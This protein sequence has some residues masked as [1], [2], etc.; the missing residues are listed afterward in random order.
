M[1]PVPVQDVP[2]YKVVREAQS[3]FC[4]HDSWGY[5]NLCSLELVQEHFVELETGKLHFRYSIQ[6]SSYYLLYRLSEWHYHGLACATGSEMMSS[7]DVS[8]RLVQKRDRGNNHVNVDK[9][10][11]PTLVQQLEHRQQAR[12]RQKA[13]RSNGQD[14]LHHESLAQLN[15]DNNDAC[16]PNHQLSDKTSPTLRSRVSA[17][18]QAVNND[19]NVSSD[20]MECT[21][22]FRSAGRPYN[23][24]NTRYSHQLM[25][26]DRNISPAPHEQAE[27]HI[28]H[29]NHIAS[30]C[31]WMTSPEQENSSDDRKRLGRPSM[32]Q[33]ETRAGTS[34]NFTINDN[35]SG[36]TQE[37]QWNTVSVADSGVPFSRWTQQVMGEKSNDQNDMAQASSSPP[38]YTNQRQL[39]YNQDSSSLRGVCRNDPPVPP[40]MSVEAAPTRQH[41]SPSP[42]H[43]IELFH[44]PR[45]MSSSPDPGD[46][47]KTKSVGTLEPECITAD[48][49]IV[50]LSNNNDTSTPNQRGLDNSLHLSDLSMHERECGNDDMC[51]YSLSSTEEREPKSR[52]RSQKNGCDHCSH[53]RP[54]AKDEYGG[55]D[56]INVYGKE[57]GCSNFSP[58]FQKCNDDNDDVGHNNNSN[59]NN[60]NHFHHYHD[61]NVN[62][63]NGLE[64]TTQDVYQTHQHTLI[65][66]PLSPEQTLHTSAARAALAMQHLV[67]GDENPSE[68]GRP[69]I[70][71][72]HP[73]LT[74]ATGT[75]RPMARIQSPPP[76]HSQ[77]KNRRDGTPTLHSSIDRAAIGSLLYIEPRYQ[78]RL[79]GQPLKRQGKPDSI[80]Q[81]KENVLHTGLDTVD[82]RRQSKEQM[83]S[84]KVHLSR[85]A[86]QPVVTRGTTSSDISMHS[87]TLAVQPQSLSVGPT[88]GLENQRGQEINEPI[89]ADFRSAKPQTQREQ[90]ANSISHQTQPVV[91][92]S[93]ELE[94]RIQHVPDT[95]TV[96]SCHDNTCVTNLQN[97]S[98]RPNTFSNVKRD[99]YDLREVSLQEEKHIQPQERCG[100]AI[101]V[102]CVNWESVEHRHNISFRFNAGT[103]QAIPPSTTKSA[104]LP[105]NIATPSEHSNSPDPN[106]IQHIL[107]AVNAENETQSNMKEG[108][109][110]EQCDTKLSSNDKHDYYDEG[111][112]STSLPGCNSR[113]MHWMFMH[114]HPS[115]GVGWEEHCEHQISEHMYDRDEPIQYEIHSQNCQN[116]HER[117]ISGPHSRVQSDDSSHWDNRQLTMSLQDLPT[118][119]S[120]EDCTLGNH[121]SRWS[122][123]SSRS[124][125]VIGKTNSLKTEPLLPSPIKSFHK[126]E[127]TPSSPSFQPPNNG[128]DGSRK[129][130]SISTTSTSVI[131]TMKIKKSNPSNQAVPLSSDEEDIAAPATNS[132]TSARAGDALKELRY[133]S[134]EH[135]NGTNKEPAK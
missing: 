15:T 56:D 47:S 6:P 108:N 113:A 86:Q 124:T 122:S 72:P 1:Q 119:Y 94:E 121:R 70:F 74:S 130:N 43:S 106:H 64:S 46:L 90:K 25:M 22:S 51:A 34:T 68:K 2:R 32:T 37:T 11:P 67:P 42:R 117:S 17:A 133:R 38:F 114:V 28:A 109:A 24:A 77:K 88:Q 132:R 13:S 103:S 35:H 48:H 36:N 101:Y 44:A 41:T 50:P 98:N 4:L 80:L 61:G 104:Q 5:D 91:N 16:P 52:F 26:G 84:P 55:G 126:H 66:Q 31:V 57:K 71:S 134:R 69:H 100:D 95:A 87:N 49:H 58:A 21:N 111:R 53:G 125:E 18:P 107:K 112:F 75:F 83:A 97:L 135:A 14:A 120:A 127:N 73:L 10:S 110:N 128:S 102:S 3:R 78:D 116:G 79:S 8:D 12:Q 123:N 54:R 23:V 85:D 99:Q 40:Q 118:P 96:R 131:P 33:T 65:H 7:P 76:S 27:H 59:D 30:Q 93:S 105:D 9:H 92:G 89:G 29:A 19:H 82:R 129:T 45:S 60:D 63:P 20:H 62:D 115:S 39:R 81:R